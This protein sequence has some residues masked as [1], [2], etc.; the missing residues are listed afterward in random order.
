MKK[1]VQIFNENTEPFRP[2]SLYFQDARF[3]L[4]L[5]FH[6]YTSHGK[7]NICSQI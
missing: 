7:K 3:K 6:F 4:L 5:L 1:N 2:V